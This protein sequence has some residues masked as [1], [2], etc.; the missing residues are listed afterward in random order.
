[1]DADEVNKELGHSLLTCRFSTQRII[2]AVPAFT[3]GHFPTSKPG[4]VPL[5][6]LCPGFEQ[7]AVISRSRAWIHWNNE[8]EHS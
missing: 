6:G 1:M 8:S 4:R 7:G 2:I 5:R 3:E